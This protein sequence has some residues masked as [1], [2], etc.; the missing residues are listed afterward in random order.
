MK[1]F[2]QANLGILLVPFL[3]LFLF[4][5]G[6]NLKKYDY[7]YELGALII[8]SINA[9]LSL[10][11]FGFRLEPLE[12]FL[13]SGHLSLTIFLLVMFTGVLPKKSKTFKVL[14][15]VRGQLAILGFIFLLPHAFNKLSLALAGYN[16]TG[17]IAF[18]V[19][20]PLVFTSF[21]P[22]RKKM[23]PKHWKK[24]HQLS[25]VTYFMLYLH[26]GFDILIGATFSFRFSQYSILYH[27]LLL[28]YI[29][30]RIYYVTLPKMKKKRYEG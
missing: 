20:I 4:Y 11:L 12:R 2:L 14:M 26:L 25:Y 16:S 30:L 9:L 17:L 23:D 8:V 15:Q 7:R 18:I 29:G 22:I 3:F 1:Y 6:K 27:L 5:F 28:L 10:G 19:F 13:Q 24:L 21:M